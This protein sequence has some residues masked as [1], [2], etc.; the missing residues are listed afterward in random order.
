MSR[1]AGV[2][3]S[4][5]YK[6]GAVS[7]GAV[8][9]D[10]SAFES[11]RPDLLRLAAAMLRHSRARTSADD[12]VQGTL[13]R[14]YGR[15]DAGTLRIDE[16]D[17]PRKFAYTTL[18]NLFRDE[19]KSSRAREEPLEHA[20]DTAAGSDVRAGVELDELLKLLGDKERAFLVCV[21]LEE[22]TVGEAQKECGWPERS[23]YYHLRRLL[24]RLRGEDV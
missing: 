3:V 21:L 10:F 14:I 8:A 4:A 5:G 11:L 23:P 13:T 18:R 7:V 2:G 6:V 24:A 15:L 12:L 19:I 17:S 9:R 16:V 20:A 1:G 22:R